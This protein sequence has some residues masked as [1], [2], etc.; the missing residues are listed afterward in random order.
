M[1]VLLYSR[2]ST[3][4]QQLEPQLI[5]LRSHT[6]RNNWTCLGE[7]SDIMTGK[8]DKRPG[9]D[10]MLT[11]CKSGDISA[12]VCV[13]LDRL[14]R[15]LLNVVTL[16]AQLEKL[17]VAII[18]TSQ[19]ID[20]RASNPTG[21]VTY[22]ILAAVA[23]FERNL[24][25]ERTKAGLVAARSRGKIL[26]RKKTIFIQ[27]APIIIREWRASNGSICELA[28]RLGGVSKTTAWRMAKALNA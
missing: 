2:V 13:K 25:S 20:T 28:F 23:E 3:E 5:E 19:S 11:R 17:G 8:R 22:Q 24:I 9:L 14:G 21:K 7:F 6:A 12:I 18:C 4:L 15:S 16:I 1:N 10:A 26:G 27:N